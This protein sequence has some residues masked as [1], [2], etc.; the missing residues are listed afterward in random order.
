MFRD[1]AG[2]AD[3]VST[4]SMENLLLNSP[5]RLMFLSACQSGVVRGESL[6]AGLG[7]GL[8]RAGVPVVVAMQFSVPV[9]AAI[10]FVGSF[11]GALGRGGTVSRAVA[12]GRRR[13]F[14]GKT[15]FIPPPLPAQPGR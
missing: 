14:R 15:W 1:S 12:H 6:F 13:L 11:Y 8:I 3:F 9:Q 5:V 2:A 10:D 4:E 7:P